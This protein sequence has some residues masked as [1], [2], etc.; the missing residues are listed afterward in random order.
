MILLFLLYN[1][2]TEKF[3][4]HVH[5][6]KTKPSE[7]AYLKSLLFYIVFRNARRSL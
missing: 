6:G 4:Q 5:K 7:T 3:S 2:H 1:S